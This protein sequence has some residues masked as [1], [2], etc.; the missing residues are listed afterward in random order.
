MTDKKLTVL[1]PNLKIKPSFEEGTAFLLKKDYTWPDS[2]NSD[3][4]KEGVCCVI[5]K[6]GL[7][8]YPTK[9]DGQAGE[10]NSFTDGIEWCL[11][12]IIMTGL[13]PDCD[14]G[15]VRAEDLQPY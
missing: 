9:T 7:S 10:W 3:Y 2:I 15:S 14:T 6:C 12:D 5:K 1:R 4:L 13:D 8:K 11:V